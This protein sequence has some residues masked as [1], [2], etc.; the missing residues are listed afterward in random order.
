MIVDRN[1][2]SFLLGMAEAEIAQYREILGDLVRCVDDNLGKLPEGYVGR[3]AIDR[4]K[5]KLGSTTIKATRLNGTP[6]GKLEQLEAI[7]DEILERWDKDMRSGKLLTALA[8]RC[9]GYRKDVD[10]IRAALAA[11]D[12]DAA[13]KREGV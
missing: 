9:H 11:A 4:A 8:G 13:T 5:A 6:M 3:R 2:H 10:E 12:H 7:C 1:S